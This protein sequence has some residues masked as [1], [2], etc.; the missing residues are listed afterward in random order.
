MDVKNAGCVCVCMSKY[1][2]RFV[3]VCGGMNVGLG[4]SIDADMDVSGGTDVAVSVGF[5]CGFSEKV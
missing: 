5:W 2:V 3:D 4:E 1:G